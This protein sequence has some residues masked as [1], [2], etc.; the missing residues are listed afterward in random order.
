MPP[1][2]ANLNP[3]QDPP[4]SEVPLP[5]A[6]LERVVAQVR[7]PKLL[8]ISTPAG[9]A[10]FQE[11]IRAKYPEFT[12][13]RLAGFP[14]GA[15]GPVEPRYETIWRFFDA[16]GVWRVSL[17][18][19]YV[20]LETKHYTS[21]KEFI[22]RFAEVIDALASTLDPKSAARIGVRYVS[23]VTGPQYEAL[24]QLLRAPIHGPGVLPAFLSAHT[25]LVSEGVF[26]SKEGG[27]RTRWGYL[28]NNA[29]HEPDLLD[30]MNKPSWILDIDS[31][32]ENR[33]PFT[34]KDLTPI[35][36]ALAERCYAV[37]RGMVT[38]QFL[39]EYGGKV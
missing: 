22:Q 10:A 9:A 35:T 13:E 23:R 28:P 11:K 12:E 38:D 30:P 20:A 3:F 29:I 39:K 26:K 32:A 17:G 33:V 2:P 15:P 8:I 36:R 1:A 21:R 7:F 31:Y 37:F 25:V 34:S 6:P 5:R 14:F 4:P 16:S 27:V 19:D 24:G 18:T